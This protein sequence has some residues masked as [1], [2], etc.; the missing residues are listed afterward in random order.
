MCPNHLIDVDTKA[1]ITSAVFNYDGTEILASYNDDDI[2]LFDLAKKSAEEKTDHVSKRF[3]GHRNSNTVKGVNFYGPKS[4]FV[5]SGSDCG[6]IFIWSKETEAIIHMFEGDEGGVVNVLE[7]HPNLPFLATSG[8]D[9][10]VKIWHPTSNSPI[11]LDLIE[12]VVTRNTD[13]KMRGIHEPGLSDGQWMI[14]VLRQFQ[15]SERRRRLRER[16]EEEVGRRLLDIYFPQCIQL[17]FM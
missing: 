9:D 10:E 13:G 12:K 1:N 5:I 7:T 6:N 16:N 4:E 15:R 17:Q 8:L 14:N 3:M 2:Y 11:A